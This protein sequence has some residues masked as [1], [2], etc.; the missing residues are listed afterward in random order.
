MLR[1]FP[2]ARRT[3][4][5]AFGSALTLAISLAAGAAV[6]TAATAAPAAAQRSGRSAAPQTQN[7]EAFVKP[8]EPVAAIVTAETGD[9]ASA[10]PQIPGLVA[11]IQTPDDRFA[12][13]NLI[14]QLGNKT[15]DA[16]LQ[17]QGLALMV[18]SGKADPAQLGQFQFFIGSLADD[19]MG[20]AP[21]GAA[22]QAAGAAG[23]AEGN[24]EA[25]M[26]ETYFG[27]NQAA[28]GLDY[29]KGVVDR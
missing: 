14:L 7:S 23:Y 28:Q 17:R 24:P 1:R 22:V 25:V 2:S 29:L 15:S 27:E 5:R 9:F 3:S 20:W 12:A 4:V 6:V 16:Q 19:A 8:Y 11:A 10:K 13:R 21:A 18:A 26:A